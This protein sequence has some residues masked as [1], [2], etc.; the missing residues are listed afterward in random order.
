MGNKINMM[1]KDNDFHDD[2]F[3]IIN[4]VN[5]TKYYKH[6]GKRKVGGKWTE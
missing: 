6:Q 2:C 3:Q 4:N 1:E 5:E